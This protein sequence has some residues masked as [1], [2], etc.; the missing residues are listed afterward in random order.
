MSTNGA[1]PKPNTLVEL[2]V[3][4]EAGALVS[5]L[6]ED[7]RSIDAGLAQSNAL[8]SGLDIHKVS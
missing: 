8:G 7:T 1:S 4:G 5:L 2:R 3:L 6:A